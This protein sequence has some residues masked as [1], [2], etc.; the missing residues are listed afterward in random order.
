MQREKNLRDTFYW[1]AIY[2]LITS[3]VLKLR[4]KVSW[5]KCNQRVFGVKLEIS[6][7]CTALYYSY[8]NVLYIYV[9]F[10]YL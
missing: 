10:Y 8:K 6:R 7:E 3:I 9:P 1:P 2:F 4:T 5:I